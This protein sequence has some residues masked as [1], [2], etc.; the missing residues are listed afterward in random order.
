[1][2]NRKPRPIMPDGHWQM[3]LIAHSRADKT[4][5]RR[6]TGTTIA[7]GYGRFR[8]HGGKVLAHRVAWELENGP[9]PTG[10]CICHR[11]DNPSCINVAHLFLGTHADN[12]AD[13][14]K[15]GRDGALY[16]ESATGA[17]L[18][19]AEA[20]AI[21]CAQGTNGAI[22]AAFGVNHRTVS[23]I[24]RKESWRHIHG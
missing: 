9:I 22:A 10:M 8:R 15:K 2:A 20:R 18:T 21:F 23:L 11:C 7:D 1:M 14:H 12:M 6:W 19:E 17:K 13:R 4:G 16:G 3:Y 24:K 5:C